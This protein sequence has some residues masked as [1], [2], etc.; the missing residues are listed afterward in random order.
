MSDADELQ[1]Q[2]AGNVLLRIHNVYEH[3]AAIRPSVERYIGEPRSVENLQIY[4]DGYQM[5]LAV[6]EISERDC[7]PFEL[8]LD[9]LVEKR[10][11]AWAH[12]WARQL[13]SES[14][15]DNEVALD[16]VFNLIAEFGSLQESE[17]DFVELV[18]GRPRPIHPIAKAFSPGVPARIQLM[19]LRPGEFCYARVTYGPDVRTLTGGMRRDLFLY[20]NAASAKQLLQRQFA[21]D[22]SEWKT[23]RSPD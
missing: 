15:G 10:P 5:A 8:F 1:E 21:L 12:G 13:L 20:S 2:C 11:G 4:L 17:G 14:G 23:S 6:H 18:A 22:P 19:N 3:L 9:W 16:K 7:P